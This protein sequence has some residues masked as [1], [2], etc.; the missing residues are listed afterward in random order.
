LAINWPINGQLGGVIETINSI[1][2]FHRQVRKVIKT[3][4]VFTSDAVLIKL[5]YLVVLNVEKEWIKPLP[6]WALTFSQFLS[7][8]R[9]DSGPT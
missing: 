7:C 9:K 3:K 4:G 8:L 2:G 6:N 1:E 5:I